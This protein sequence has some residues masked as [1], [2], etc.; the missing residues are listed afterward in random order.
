MLSLELLRE[1]TDGLP[2]H[3]YVL[4]EDRLVVYKNV[5]TGEVKKFSHPLFFSKKG[6]K[7]RKLDIPA[8]LKG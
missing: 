4:K 1:T 6:R 3:L 8:N 5:I 7:F 2:P